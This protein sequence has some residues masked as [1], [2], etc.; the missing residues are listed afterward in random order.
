MVIHIYTQTQQH[1]NAH[2]MQL[3]HNESPPG[4]SRPPESSPPSPGGS[5]SASRLSAGAALAR[6][7]SV[8]CYAAGVLLA[9]FAALVALPLQ[10]EAQKT[11]FVSNTGQSTATSLRGIGPTG[12]GSFFY[13][14]AQGFSTGSNEGGYTLSAIKVQGR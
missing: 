12:I 8:A 13:S 3:L 2:L 4:P 11:A 7:G 5:S 1:T 14:Q 10:A 9:A 6:A